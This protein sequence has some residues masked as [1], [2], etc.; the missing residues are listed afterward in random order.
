VL[1]I[2]GAAYPAVVFGAAPGVYVRAARTPD[3]T[4]IAVWGPEHV[5]E[6]EITLTA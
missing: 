1:R 2:D 6:R 5:L 4:A 3:G